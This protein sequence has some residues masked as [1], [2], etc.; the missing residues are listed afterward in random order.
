LRNSWRARDAVLLGAG[1][2]AHWLARP[3]ETLFLCLGV[4]LF[5]APLAKTLASA[6]RPLSRAALIATL[7]ALPAIGA[8]LAQDRAVTGNWLKMPEMLSQEQYGIPAALTFLPDPVPHRA[9]TADQEDEYRIQMLFKGAKTETAANYL[10]RLRDN[11]HYYRFFFLPPAYLALPLVFTA[12]GEWTVAWTLATLA[13]FALG[14]NFF[15]AFQY[16]YLGG[17]AC[18]LLLV[19]I[20][21]LRQLARF[22]LPAAGLLAVMCAAHFVFWYDAHLLE[23]SDAVRG[24]LSQEASMGW[25]MSIDQVHPNAHE[26]VRARLADVPGKQLVFV[27]YY[28]PRHLFEDEFVY[29]DADVSGSRIVWARDLGAAEN[30]KLMR[31]YP[32]RKVWLLEPEFRLPRL[33]PYSTATAPAPARPTSGMP[34]AIAPF[35]VAPA[36]TH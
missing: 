19:G 36:K 34:R 10:R 23:S 15:P 27:H 16:H 20:V 3:Y 5:F 28:R 30:E 2:G 33:R 21:A 29:N 12:I 13:V 14:T 11:A 26:S 1:L 4:M 25:W 31:Y 7:A 8:S 22:R 18:L 32:D 6:W 9:L 17:V 24:L 35:A